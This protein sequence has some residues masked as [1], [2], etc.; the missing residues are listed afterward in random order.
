MAQGFTFFKMK[1]GAN[2][3]DD[4]YRAAVIRK[5][6]GYDNILAV[7]ANQRWDVQQAIDHMK[8]LVEFKP[9]WIEGSTTCHLY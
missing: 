5:E 3:E 7:D 2:V 6:I 1:V 4:K 9:Y 8:H